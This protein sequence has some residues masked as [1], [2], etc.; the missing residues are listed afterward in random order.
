MIKEHLAYL[1]LLWLT[2]LILLSMEYVKRYVDAT[3]R[4]VGYSG[5]SNDEKQGW[6]SRLAL[7]TALA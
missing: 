6:Y 7:P 4:V 2:V 1:T 5:S 3:H